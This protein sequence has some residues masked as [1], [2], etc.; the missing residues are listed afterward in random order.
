MLCRK[1]KKAIPD[2]SHFCNLCGAKQ[3]LAEQKPR[4]KQRG[5]GQGTVY[6]RGNTWTAKHRHLAPGGKMVSVCKGGFGTKREAL[7][8]LARICETP[9][10]DAHISFEGLY[11]KWIARHAE[12]VSKATIDCYK[13]AYKHFATVHRYPFSSLT[14]EQLQACVDACPHGVRTKENM[15]ALCT[16]LYAYAH[17]IGVTNEDYGQHIYIARNASVSGDKR[18]QAFTREELDRLFTAQYEGVGGVDVVLIMCYTGFRIGE[19]LKIG[20]ND[21]NIEQGYIVGGSK[22]KAGIGRI[23]TLSPKILPLVRARYDAASED[24]RLFTDESGRPYSEN[25]WREKQAQILSGIDGVRPLLP[26]ECRHTFA[27]LMKAVDA[28][29]EDKM[30]LIGHADERMLAHYTHTSIAELKAITDRL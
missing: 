17:E 9:R 23:V 11:A 3:V 18:K 6:K 30:R 29:K 5:N 15:K 25:R 2:G 22:T 27:T 12:R 8:Y 19:L 21:V 10:T 24:G 28:S 4:V 14:T 13:A 16:S 20:K 1:C 26:H 7:D